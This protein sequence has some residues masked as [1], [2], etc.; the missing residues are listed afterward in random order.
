MGKMATDVGT[1]G[2]S[3]PGSAIPAWLIWGARRVQKDSVS[4]LFSH[5]WGAGGGCASSK[6]GAVGFKVD[7]LFYFPK[8]SRAE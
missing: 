8:K 5:F 3:V 6:C 7:L 4:L 2:R 1:A